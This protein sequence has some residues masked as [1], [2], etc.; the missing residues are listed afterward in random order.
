MRREEE[1]QKEAE[2]KEMQP[3]AKE[4]QKPPETERGKTWILP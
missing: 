3:Q 2:I 1:V 4:C